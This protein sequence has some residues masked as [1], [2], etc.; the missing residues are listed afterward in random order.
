[1]YMHARSRYVTSC[2]SGVECT[3][4]VMCI[5]LRCS[6][7][8]DE[9]EDCVPNKTNAIDVHD[10]LLTTGQEGEVDHVGA[11]PEDTSGSICRPEAAC[12]LLASRFMILA[13]QCSCRW[14]NTHTFIEIINGGGGG[15]G[16]A[17]K[18]H[19]RISARISHTCIRMHEDITIVAF[20][21]RTH[22]IEET[23][24]IRRED[25]KLPSHCF[26][27]CR[28]NAFARSV[29]SVNPPQTEVKPRAMLRVGTQSYYVLACQ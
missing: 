11:W 27:E 6:R 22:C 19:M 14:V 25:A 10:A 4:V 29:C 8:C 16:D 28:S 21:V 26:R 24:E 9:R 23:S 20:S 13:L 1:M 3:L 17:R 15:G 2:V 12:E 18:Q 5:V 7:R